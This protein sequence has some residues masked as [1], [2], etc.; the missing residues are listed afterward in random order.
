MRRPGYTV[1]ATIL[2]SPS[3]D[4]RNASLAALLRWGVSRYRV[5]SVIARGRTYALA[6]VGYGR[7]PLRLVA[8]SRVRRAVRADRPLVARIVSTAAVSLPVRKGSRLGTVRVLQG[9]RL[10]ATRPL[11]AAQAVTRPSLAARVRFYARRTADHIWS[12]V[13]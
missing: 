13:T 2:G 12:W 3:R 7:A 1:Y 8:A 10:V 4:S 9:N 6:D 11:V 5:A